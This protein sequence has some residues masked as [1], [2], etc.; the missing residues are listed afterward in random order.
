MNDWLRYITRNAVDAVLVVCLDR[1]ALEDPGWVRILDALNAAVP[2][3]GL[4]LYG[5]RVAGRPSER[6]DYDV[7]ALVSDPA[8][9]RNRAAV[10][11]EIRERTGLPVDL[12]LATPRGFRLG[13]LVDPHARHCLA[14]GIRLGD[15]PEVAE[16][17]SRWGALDAVTVIRLDL[18]D[19]GT[20]TGETRR[21]W[22]RRVAKQV[23]ALE[24]TLAGEFDAA[25]YAER[26]RR[27]LGGPAD[28][29][30]SRMR[31]AAKAL[32]ERVAS[33]PP[34]AGDAALEAL[35]RSRKDARR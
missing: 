5:S 34:N 30:L 17:F 2:V 9:V 19:A 8:L 23:A 10:Q 21:E 31:R 35:I 3:C 28:Q 1:L 22:L 15:V 29:R 13:A 7:L 18:E 12:N 24:Q 11:R 27:L 20:F 26:V 33:L 14:T 6:S 4:I 16:P 25:A 32:E